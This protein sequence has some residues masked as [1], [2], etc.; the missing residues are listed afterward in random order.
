M[1]TADKPITCNVVAAGSATDV[2][3]FQVLGSGI[4]LVSF[5]QPFK[6]GDVV[7]GKVP[8][9]T[10]T[11]NNPL[12][13][14]QSYIA[15]NHADGSARHAILA[16]QVTGGQTYKIRSGVLSGT[17]LT[18]AG[19]LAA[20]AGDPGTVVLTGGVI[21]TLSLRDILS[22]ATNRASGGLVTVES[23]PKC[24]SL[25][26]A[27]DFATHLRVQCQLRWYGGTNLW[28]DVMPMNG[29]ATLA[30][31]GDK[32]YTMVVTL[33]GIQTSSTTLSTHYNKAGWHSEN[34]TPGINLTRGSL[35]I[36]HNAAYIIASGAVSNY[37]L[38][39]PMD[40]TFLN[41]VRQ[42]VAPMA[43]G[44]NS[45]NID[46]TGAQAG[47]G[48]LSQW[49]AA[50]FTSNADQRAYKWVLANEDA[51]MSYGIFWL[52]SATGQPIVAATRPTFILNDGTGLASGYNS[53][54]SPFIPSANQ[55][56]VE[57]SAHIPPLGYLGYLL[58]GSRCY[59]HA[60]QGSASTAH[61]W[62]S[63]S[64]NTAFNSQTIR[65]W[66][67]QQIRAM[68]W[69]YRDIGRCAYLTPTADP[70]A[71]YW[72]NCLNGNLANDNAQYGPGGSQVNAL[73]VIQNGDG[74]NN[75]GA[76]MHWFYV[77][78]LG[79]LTTEL[80]LGGTNG[81]NVARFVAKFVAG[82]LGATDDYPW[83]RAADS[84]YPCATANNNAS[85]YASF[86]ALATANISSTI[87]ATDMGTTAATNAVGSGDANWVAGI[88]NQINGWQNGAGAAA[89]GEPAY[90]FANLQMAAAYL[91]AIN[92]PGAW[93]AWYRMTLSGLWPDYSQQPQFSI[94]PRALT[95]PA[96]WKALTPLVPTQIASTAL[97]SVDPSPVPA[98]NT[99]PSA[100]FVAW[101]TSSVKAQGSTIYIVAQGGHTDYAGN[102]DDS[103][104]LFVDAPHWSQIL[105]PTPAG[106]VT[107]SSGTG[108]YADGRPASRHGYYGSLF[109]E[110][111][112]QAVLHGCAF[113]YGN[114]DPSYNNVDTF[115]T[116]TL[117]YSVAGTH[118]ACADSQS[119]P[120][121]YSLAS[122]LI[123]YV[124]TGGSFRKYNLAKNTDTQIAGVG[125]LETERSGACD[126]KRGVL[127]AASGISTQASAW[128][129]YSI[130]TGAESARGGTV[131]LSGGQGSLEYDCVSD[132]YLW[133][134]ADCSALFAINPTTFAK[135]TLISSGMPPAPANGLYGKCRFVPEL[136]GVVWLNSYS[137][138]VWFARL[139]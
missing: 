99:G 61:M 37:D 16:A 15:V 115:D 109:W 57:P 3:T 4:A 34:A 121:A 130:D 83:Q 2:T 96:W 8:I 62:P 63:S 44:D 53:S 91:R 124:T 128:T 55:L 103:L 25:E 66:H 50:Y 28:L 139:A 42:S 5:A 65:L 117:S 12:A 76:F 127:L 60:M 73:G 110:G 85:V 30:G 93:K 94:V 111:K 54:A 64:Q 33:N 58:T 38:T 29:Y 92:V 72:N 68:A 135:S 77:G 23:G 11:S 123:Y 36:Q 14:C 104:N 74:V 106:S 136:N 26:F 81:Q 40:S 107:A 134:P 9:I 35:Y 13:S 79:H 101:G 114:P 17:A 41:G 52:D 71:A 21:G 56:G 39:R 20:F 19:L 31:S 32:T 69:N 133:C 1:T 82:L 27:Q 10:D 98:G 131:G 24:L 84:R 95:M 70:L 138:N 75:Y 118:V 80:G 43:I 49:G 102:E 46:D 129:S 6:A 67:T 45:P 137:G 90:Y 120:R 112:D 119:I 88:R 78:S 18:V 116:A 105:A 97:S 132:R 89:S 126:P 51:A 22:S 86:A 125:A 7:A 122:G 59:L 100:K 47:I 87:L 108:Y 48:L 113:V